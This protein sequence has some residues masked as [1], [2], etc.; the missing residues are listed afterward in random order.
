[1]AALPPTQAPGTAEYAGGMRSFEYHSSS[2]SSANLSFQM[3]LAPLS[4][5]PVATQR[6]LALLAKTHQSPLFPQAM[7]YYPLAS[8]CTATMQSTF[9]GPIWR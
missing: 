2:N 9:R 6:A 5:T 1:M 8:A 3:R 4:S 7:A